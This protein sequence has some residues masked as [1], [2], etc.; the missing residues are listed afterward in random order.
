MATGGAVPLSVRPLLPADFCRDEVVRAGLRAAA[1]RRELVLRLRAD[2]VLDIVQ[3]T[4][5]G[6]HYRKRLF[7]KGR[8]AFPAKIKTA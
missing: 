5:A 6:V 4:I 1:A 7:L 2:L 8:P 3:L